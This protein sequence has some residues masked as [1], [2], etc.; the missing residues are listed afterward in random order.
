MSQSGFDSQ[1]GLQMKERKNRRIPMIVLII[2][3]LLAVTGLSLLIALRKPS[4]RKETR[5]PLPEK[6]EIMIARPEPLTDSDRNLMKIADNTTL[7]ADRKEN[8]DVIGWIYLPDT[9]VNDR[10]VWSPYDNEFYLRKDFRKNF[11]LDGEI[12]LDADNSPSFNEPFAFLF[13]HNSYTGCKFSD[14]VKYFDKPDLKET[15][16]YF[17]I[18]TPERIFRYRILGTSMIEPVNDI[19]PATEENLATNRNYVEEHTGYKV[20]SEDRIIYLATCVTMLDSSK[21]RLVIGLLD[22]SVNRKTETVTFPYPAVSRVP[23]D[24]PEAR[25][26]RKKG[27]ILPAGTDPE[28]WVRKLN[29]TPDASDGFGK[30]SDD[31]ALKTE[32]EM[33][34]S[35]SD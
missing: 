2:L 14:L 27:L 18:L 12:F 6:K 1:K 17:Y 25:E 13:G 11:L 19:Y 15:S 7:S 30:P 23:E 29:D 16:P 10:I 28:R 5:K 21:R 34:D 31:P 4:D 8:P 3:L 33:T 35:E 9:T 22:R 32:P 20:K 24:S 26:A